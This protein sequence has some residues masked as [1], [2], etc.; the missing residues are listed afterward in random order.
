MVSQSA[1][2]FL[3]YFALRIREEGGGSDKLMTN[4]DKGGREVLVIGDVS[5]KNNY[6]SNIK[7]SKN[8]IFAVT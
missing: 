3:S 1:L 5:I 4:G 7:M 8:L 2:Y 6:Y